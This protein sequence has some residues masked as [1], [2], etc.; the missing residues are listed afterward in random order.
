MMVL[1]ASLIRLVRP[2]ESLKGRSGAVVLASGT[3][4][5]LLAGA[6]WAYLAEYVHVKNLSC[7]AIEQLLGSLLISCQLYHLGGR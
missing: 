3:I 6:V 4:F 5:I 1:I 7:R 2:P